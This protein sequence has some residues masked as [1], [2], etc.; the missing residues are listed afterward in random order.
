MGG[1]A[2]VIPM[3]AQRTAAEGCEG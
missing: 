1:V 2:G 3:L